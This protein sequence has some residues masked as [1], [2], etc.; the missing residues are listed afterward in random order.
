[1]PSVKLR[2]SCAAVVLALALAKLAHTWLLRTGVLAGALPDLV[3]DILLPIAFV[4]WALYTLIRLWG[5]VDQIDPQR[6][7]EDM[8]QAVNERHRRKK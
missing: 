6:Q 3:R 8:W 7:Q 4:A 2:R 1:M 5:E